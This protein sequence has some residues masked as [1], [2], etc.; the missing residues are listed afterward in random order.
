MVVLFACDD[1]IH[2]QRAR[3]A[4]LHPHDELATTS[5]PPGV[6]SYG[7]LSVDRSVNRPTI[8]LPKPSHFR[9]NCNMTMYLLN[10]FGNAR[11]EEGV[12]WNKIK[13]LQLLLDNNVI[14]LTAEETTVAEA[15]LAAARAV[16]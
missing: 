11:A 4:P 7:Q 14:K 8:A 12:C 3:I 1:D 9:A 16:A 6:S 13:M 15:A 5:L 10:G 2:T